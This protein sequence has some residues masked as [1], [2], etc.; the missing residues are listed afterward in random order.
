[1]SKQL[2]KGNEAIA[3]AAIRAGCKLFFGYPITPSTEIVEYLAKHLPKAGGTVLQGEDEIAS[4]NMCYGAAATGTRVMTASSSPGFSLKQEGLSYLAAV[5]LPVVVVNVNRAGP[6]LGGLGPSQADYFQCTKGGG[7]GDYR[8]IV[9]APSKGQ[10]LYD[11]T[12]EAFDLADKYRNPVLIMADGFLGQMMEPVELKER[13]RQPLPP[14]DWAVGGCRG[15]AKRKIASYSLTNEIGEANCLHW[16]AKYEQIR[17]LEQRWEAFYAD[18]AE[19]LLVG[20]GTCGRI[21]KSVVQSARRQGLK[22]GLIRPITLWPFPE[23]A[24]IRVKDRVKGILTVELNAGQMI[25]DIKLAVECRV[26]VHLYNRQG[27]MLPTEHEILTHLA[28]VFQLSL[29]EEG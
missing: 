24:F 16:Q 17:A 1:M 26:P 9:L 3:E 4:I 10:E 8:L 15:R 22:V 28:K 23:K 29:A 6:G 27:G 19:Y 21:A 12:M 20:Y 13:P 14:K 25:E 2:M 11:F 5:E 7:H 18:D